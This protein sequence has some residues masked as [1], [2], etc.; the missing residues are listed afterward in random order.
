MVE[1]TKYI[2][3]GWYRWYVDNFFNLFK[4]RIKKTKNR[5]MCERER[6]SVSQVSFTGFQKI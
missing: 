3:F 6:L 5:W 4:K 1:K 2:Y